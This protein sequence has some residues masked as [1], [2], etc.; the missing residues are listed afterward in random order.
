MQ[1]PKI[2]KIHHLGTIAE[3]C[4]PISSQLRHVLTIEKI[5]KQQY[6]LSHMF[7]Q[8]G[9]LRPSNGWDLLAHLEHPIKFQRVSRL[10]SVTA[11]HSSSGRQPK[12]A[13]LNTGRHVHSEGRPS[14]WALTHHILVEFRFY[15]PLN[16]PIQIG[17]FGDVPQA[18]LLAWYRK[19]KP[20]TTRLRYMLNAW[21]RVRVIYIFVLYCIKHA[22]TNHGV[23]VAQTI[24]STF[25]HQRGRTQIKSIQHTNIKQKKSKKHKCTVKSI[26]AKVS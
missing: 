2:A 7:S 16:R 23:L 17:H 22:F 18:S 24:L 15:V 13:A 25:I 3:L 20:N 11:R 6:C 26:K 10:G 4:R 1:G 9:E 14:R 5:V 8:Y 19:T 12:F 21:L